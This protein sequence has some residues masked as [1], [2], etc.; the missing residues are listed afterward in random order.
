[1]P[2]NLRKVTLRSEDRYGKRLP[3][4]TPASR[5]VRMVGTLGVVRASNQTFA[6]MLGSG[7]QVRGVLVQGRIGD[8]AS[9]L[10]K[11]VLTFGRSVFR[12]S[13]R[14][15]RLEVNE[16]RLASEADQFFAKV[17]APMGGTRRQPTPRERE[18]AAEGLRAVIGKWPGEETEEQIAAALKELG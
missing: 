13:G 11:Q 4:E 12:P 17:P 7:E 15:L 2:Q 6:L 9:L 18:W 10:N 16:Y 5:R 3:H 1:M 8:L 14:L